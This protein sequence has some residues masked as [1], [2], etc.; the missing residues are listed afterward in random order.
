MD[1][2]G[3]FSCTEDVAARSYHSFWLAFVCLGAVLPAVLFLSLTT[4][5]GR[6][7]DAAVQV[8]RAAQCQELSLK[9]TILQP[10]RLLKKQEG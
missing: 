9:M 7:C 10:N 2:L 4:A 8:S 3:T 1:L 6:V 5:F